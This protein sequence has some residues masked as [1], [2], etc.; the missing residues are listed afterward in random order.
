MSIIYSLISKGATVLAEH[1]N[2]SGNFIT[3]SRVIIEKIPK[4]D[5]KLSY[6]YDSFIFHFV[7]EGGVIYMCMTDYNF[8]RRIGFSF[9]EDIKLRFNASYSI[10]QINN[11]VA[12]S[13]NNE[14]APF[15]SRQMDFFSRDPSVDKIS[16][17]K[18]QL[19]ETKQIMVENIEKILNRSEKI[20][21]LVR[22]TESLDQ[23]SVQF[24]K[25][26]KSLSHRIWWKNVKL[27]ILSVFLLFVVIWLL[28]SF[29][30]G[31]NYSKCWKTIFSITLHIQTTDVF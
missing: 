30:C 18:H 22:Q 7:V 6:D 25:S 20:D 23:Q 15:L 17:A 8:P 5:A 24:H 14:F 29:I 1:S 13:M 12:F 4:E 31:F 21:I 28:S 26:S 10:H 9:L 2:A 3:L 27:A 16:H 19:E 11:A